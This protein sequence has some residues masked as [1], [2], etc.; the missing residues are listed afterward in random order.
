MTVNEKIGKKVSRTKG[1]TTFSYSE[2]G[3]DPGEYGA[4]AKALERLVKGGTIERVSAGIFYKPKATV[5]GLIKPGEEELLRTYLFEGNKRVAYISGI[6]LYNKMGLTTQ[7]PK[8]IKIACRDKKISGK[9]GTVKIMPVKSYVDI[10]ND[11]YK[12]LGILDA[13]KDFK[14]IPDLEIKSAIHRILQVIQKLPPSDVEK[15][16]RIGIKYPP[17]VRA[18]LGALLSNLGFPYVEKLR[19]SLN[20]LSEYELGIKPSQLST[21]EN[22]NIK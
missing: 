20:P 19:K 4:A 14:N 5:F 10:T 15:L 13:L 1:G 7:V 11:N 9:V 2:L 22:W 3:I 8:T 6:A 16:T 12:L 21:V 18:F 17:R